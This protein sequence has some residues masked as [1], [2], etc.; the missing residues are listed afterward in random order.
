MPRSKR[1]RIV[2]LTQTDKKGFERKEELIND[3]RESIDE[4]ENLF[5]FDLVNQKNSVLKTI[6]SEWHHSKFF[7]G[8]NKVIHV[9]LGREEQEEYVENIAG[10]VKYITGNCGL[11]FT[12][13]S[14]EETKEYFNNFTES[15]YANPGSLAEKSIVLP[16]GHL[17]F[18]ASMYEQLNL[19]HVPVR[20]RKG[21]LELPEEYI[22]CSI[23]DILSPSQC[24]LLKLLKIEL[25]F[26]KIVLKACFNIKNNTITDI[27]PF[28]NNND[29]DDED[30]EEDDSGGNPFAK[31]IKK[32]E[33]KAKKKK[34]SK[35]KNSMN[36]D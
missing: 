32:K 14:V 16:K 23:G 17:S 1:N 18:P 20:L 6:R 12:N 28:D 22:V 21:V 11:L 33:K 24:R 35:K 2:H 8:K 34:K 3:I 19:L 36:E 7:L 9:A 10:L 5:V 15:T 30:D 31:L 27:S 13:K 29:E 4:F 26:F 25:S